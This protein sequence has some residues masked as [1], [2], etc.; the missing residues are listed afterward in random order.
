MFCVTHRVHFFLHHRV[1]LWPW[2]VP[3]WAHLFTFYSKL[4]IPHFAAEKNLFVL[5][6]LCVTHRVHFFLPHR[7]QSLLTMVPRRAHLFTFYSK[8]CIP[9]FAAE[10]IYFCIKHSLCYPSCAL[11]FCPIVCSYYFEWCPIKR[12]C[13]LIIQRLV[14]FILLLKKCLFV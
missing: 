2:M 6:I 14:Y 13:L 12:T 11:F 1:Q 4:G 3:R 10:K 9:H 8:V 5:N 7:V